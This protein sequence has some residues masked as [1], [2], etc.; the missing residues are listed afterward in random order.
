MRLLPLCTLILSFSLVAQNGKPEADR[1]TLANGDVLT[2]T[3]KS[4]ADGKLVFTQQSLAD[5]T[6]PMAK[7]ADL[8]TLRPVRLQTDGGEVIERRIIGIKDGQLLLAE[9][10]AGAPAAPSFALDRL[11]AINPPAKV[12][13]W[14]G[15]LAIGAEYVTGNTERRS[16]NSDFNAERRSDDDRITAA[17]F[18][19]YSEDK[20]EAT[21]DWR[22]SQ[23]KA[24]GNLKYDYFLSKRSYLYATT[25]AEGDTRADIALRFTAG[26]G[27][28]YQFI[29]TPDCKLGA[30]IGVSYFSED[31]RSALPTSEYVAG[32]AAYKFE[33]KLA[34]RLLFKQ[35]VEAFFGFE[36]G[37]DVFVKTD[38]RLIANLTDSM[39][40][41]LKVTFDWD[42]TPATGRDRTDLG[43]FLSVGW[44]F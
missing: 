39:I 36:H 40:A 44:T 14:S 9:G 25:S 43:A 17:A 22:L 30:E 24:G 33:K 4:M 32:R 29:E 31:Y 16:V 5:L 8:Q 37:D 1:L 41:Q 6:I 10:A 11:A 18:W 21:K 23:R 35:I 42:N 12:V 26:V 13:K 27:Y 3:V 20:D 7:V 2:G 28:G 34:E 15:S 19:N 38:S